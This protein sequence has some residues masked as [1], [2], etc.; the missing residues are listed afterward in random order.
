MALGAIIRHRKP[1][2]NSTGSVASQRGSTWLLLAF[3]GQQWGRLRFRLSSQCP[4]VQDMKIKHPSQHNHFVQT[5]PV[6][7]VLFFLSQVPGAPDDN[8]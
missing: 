4:G 5:T 3:Y 7:I 6:Y 1:E 2:R 8:R